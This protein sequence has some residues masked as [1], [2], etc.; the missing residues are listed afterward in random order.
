[1]ARLKQKLSSNRT[2]ILYGCIATGSVLGGLT[3]YLASVV[4]QLGSPFPWAT[5]FVNVTGSF[6][7]GF[8]N[9]LSGPDGRLFVS[10]QQRQFVMTG[11]CGGYTTFSTFS[12][13][14]VRLLGAGMRQTALLNIFISLVSWLL[15]VWLGHLLANRLNR[16]KGS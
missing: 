5:L 11:F 10:A 7:I 2:F 3:R 12:L 14:T 1:M 13:E 8:Y 4:F 9:T 15:A 16:L 6:I